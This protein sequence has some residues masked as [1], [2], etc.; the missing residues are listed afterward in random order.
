MGVLLDT[1]GVVLVLR[2]HP[3]PGTGPFVEATRAEILGGRAILPSVAV[4]ELL[5][6]ERSPDG[7][8]RLLEAL[9]HLPS[10][11]LPVEAALT[12][13][14]MGS[15]LARQGASV[16][17]PDLL[18]AATAVWLDLPLMTWDGDFA[19]AR[20]QAKE[21][22]DHPGAQAWRALALHPASRSA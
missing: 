4:S 18:V 16:P 7:V 21:G 19:R 1:S 14:N 13:G 9:L 17:F 10:V 12:A 5:V 3:P 6:G 11:I 8:R 22:G 2:R 20:G 15:F